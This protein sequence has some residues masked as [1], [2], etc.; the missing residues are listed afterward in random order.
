MPLGDGLG[1]VNFP[2]YNFW[3]SPVGIG[4]WYYPPLFFEMG[5]C[6]PWPW[7]TEPPA[8]GMFLDQH[9]LWVEKNHTIAY[10]FVI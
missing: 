4:H 1:P 2:A 3:K 7:P 5:R 8:A 6:L 9:H 10:I